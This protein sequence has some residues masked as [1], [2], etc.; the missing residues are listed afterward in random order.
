MDGVLWQLKVGG[1]ILLAFTAAV[2]LAARCRRWLR[3]RPGRYPRWGGVAVW[4]CGLAVFVF[5][6][7]AFGYLLDRSA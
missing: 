3:R 6:M 4:G 5:L 1:L 2:W 7:L